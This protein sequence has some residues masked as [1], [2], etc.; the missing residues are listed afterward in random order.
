MAQKNKKYFVI[1][2]ATHEYGFVVHAPNEA[3]AIKKA[4]RGRG[5]ELYNDFNEWQEGTE[6]TEVS[7]F[8]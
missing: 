5:R 2:L 8:P 6:K 1:L 4:K 7:Q 3:Q